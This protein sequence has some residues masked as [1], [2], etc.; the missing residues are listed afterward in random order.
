MRAFGVVR[1]F[2]SPRSSKGAGQFDFLVPPLGHGQYN[3]V[4]PLLMGGKGVANRPREGPADGTTPCGCNGWVSPVAP[5]A[6][7]VKIA[8]VMIQNWG[9][10]LGIAPEQRRMH[11]AFATNV[12][13]A[14]P[15]TTSSNGS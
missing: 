15:T 8:K 9:R 12:C 6:K 14:G 13:R 11:C 2:V 7:R 4:Q 10:E 1:P 5:S 3:K